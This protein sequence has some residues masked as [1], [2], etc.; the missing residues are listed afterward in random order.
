MLEQGLANNL[1]RYRTPGLSLSLG[2]WKYIHFDHVICCT[3][4]CI[5]NTTY[6]WWW[7][8]NSTE[9]GASDV[10][11]SPQKF[12]CDANDVW[13]LPLYVFTPLSF[14][15]NLISS[16]SPFSPGE[17]NASLVFSFCKALR[18]P[19]TEFKKTA[20]E[21][22]LTELWFP[23]SI[24]TGLLSQDISWNPGS[25]AALQLSWRG[26]STACLAR[27]R[28]YYMEKLI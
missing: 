1:G 27:N 20:M 9:F 10:T 23:H 18:P 3:H 24:H 26:G 28:F 22:K 7:D 15:F 17:V 12:C 13:F 16:F 2:S 14:F 5:S 11:H 19:V 21:R 25:C 6:T 8:A 4:L